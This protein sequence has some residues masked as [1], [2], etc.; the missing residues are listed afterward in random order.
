[1]TEPR[2]S[3]M[4][5]Q[6][7]GVNRD[8][9]PNLLKDLDQW[10]VWKALKKDNGSKVSKV[11]IDPISGRNID[12][13]N[14][15]NHMDF[16]TAFH[17]YEIGS[18]SGIG[19]VLT[20]EP[21]KISN[22]LFYIV[23]VDIDNVIDSHAKNCARKLVKNIGSYCEISP[24]GN[25]VRVFALS[26]IPVGKGQS[27]SGEMYYE[28]RFL[29]VTGRGPYRKLVDASNVLQS[30]EN[31]WWPAIKSCLE[32]KSASITPNFYPETPR[33]RAELSDLLN[34]ISSDCSY[35]RYRGVVWAI[36]GTGW[37]DAEILAKSWCLKA[38]DR[39]NENDFFSLV[40]SFNENHEN[41]ITVGSLKFWAKEAGWGGDE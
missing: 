21:L 41:P 6:K 15:K 8:T 35:E 23:G 7:L 29:T 25:G 9:I 5:T 18:G 31:Q 17:K 34:Y 37:P 22:K 1:M 24:S 10:V 30:I 16:D 27:N 4:A 12:A 13:L 33:R 19:F 40:K 38:P 39:Y 26:S 2:N 32:N 11:P 14:K 20:G 36:L 3:Q 28:K